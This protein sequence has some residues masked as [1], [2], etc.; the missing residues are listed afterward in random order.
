[1]HLHH[2]DR[3]EIQYEHSLSDIRLNLVLGR[4]GH[5][6]RTKQYTKKKK[7]ENTQ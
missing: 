7:N 4:Y 6:G 5:P 1:M 2:N 3:K